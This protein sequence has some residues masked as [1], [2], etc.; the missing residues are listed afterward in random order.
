VTGVMQGIRI[1]EVAE[2]PQVVANGYIQEGRT[3]EGVPYRLVTPPVQFDEQPSRP[4]RA[5][6]FSEHGDEILSDL[7]GLEWDAIVDLKLKGV[8]A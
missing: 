1:L 5:P 3:K 4:L 6:E 2:D 7:L 8:V